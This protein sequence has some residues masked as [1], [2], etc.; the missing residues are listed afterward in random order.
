MYCLLNIRS[1]AALAAN[2]A[3]IIGA[4]CSTTSCLNLNLMYPWRKAMEENSSGA[5]DIGVAESAG[6]P[7]SVFWY[8]GLGG[9]DLFSN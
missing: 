7:G 2:D 9:S 6:A 5:F 8:L 4:I 1:S 3:G